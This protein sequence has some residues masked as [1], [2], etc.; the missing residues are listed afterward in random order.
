M[1]SG[2][3]TKPGVPSLVDLSTNAMI[4]CLGAVS[5]HEGSGSAARDFITRRVKAM[6]VGRNF[7]MMDGFDNHTGHLPVGRCP[8]REDG[9]FAGGGHVL[10]L[11]FKRIEA[12]VARLLAGWEFLE[13]HEEPAGDGLQRHEHE[14]A[15]DHPVV[16]GVRV[17]L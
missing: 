9:L 10:D 13:G 17:V 5:F 15:V 3:G 16:I 1:R 14:G 6:T 8:V 7:M 12:P 4:A 11:L 2:M